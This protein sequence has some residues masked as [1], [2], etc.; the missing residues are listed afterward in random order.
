MAF[1]QFTS[2][3]TDN[4]GLSLTLT[5][6]HPGGNLYDLFVFNNGPVVTLGT[7]PAWSS[8]TARSVNLQLYDGIWT[9]AAQMTLFY[10]GGGP[11]FTCL[12]YECTYVGSVYVTTT[13]HTCMQFQPTAAAGGVSTCGTGA[14]AGLWN[15]YNRVSAHIRIKDSNAAWNAVTAAWEAADYSNGGANNNLNN[16]INFVDGL[17]VVQ[18]RASVDQNNQSTSGVTPAP[19]PFIG[20]SFDWASPSAPDVICKQQA[21]QVISV[22]CEAFDTPLMGLHYVQAVEQAAGSSGA[23][24]GSNLV[25]ALDWE[26]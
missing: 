11:S 19:K 15:A 18:P 13:G 23:P 9:N 21:A 1:Y 14:Y 2:S 24:F 5:S 8:T 25:T 4:V 20:V 3:P 6:S 10:T 26:Y 16:R 12:P 22:A 7:G 17:Q